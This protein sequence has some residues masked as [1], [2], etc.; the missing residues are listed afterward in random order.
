M[1]L[2]QAARPATFAYTMQKPASI[3]AFY[4]GLCSCKCTVPRGRCGYRRIRN[5]YDERGLIEFGVLKT[6][7][8]RP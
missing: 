8:Y 5:G 1:W 3:A 7:P 2:I 4:L 6:I